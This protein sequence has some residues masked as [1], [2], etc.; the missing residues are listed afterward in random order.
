MNWLEL[1]LALFFAMGCAPLAFFQGAC[2]CCSG[3]PCGSNG[4]CSSTPI[5]ATVTVSGFTNNGCPSCANYNATYIANRDSGFPFPAN[6][7]WVTSGATK[8]CTMVGQGEGVTVEFDVVGADTRITVQHFINGPT[9][10]PRNNILW[11]DLL[12]TAPIA[13]GGFGTFTVPYDS[14]FDAGACTHDLSDVTVT[15]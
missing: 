2:P 7:R 3:T 15:I 6:C 10:T 11:R 1:L 8:G 14:T 4:S 12:G 9:G 13:C 5:N